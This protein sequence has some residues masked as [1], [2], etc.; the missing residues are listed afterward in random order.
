MEYG[1]LI[2]RINKAIDKAAL[3][4][5]ASNVHIIKFGEDFSKLSG[6]VVILADKPKPTAQDTPLDQISAP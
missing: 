1:S 4:A 3:R 6:L 2:K 5:T